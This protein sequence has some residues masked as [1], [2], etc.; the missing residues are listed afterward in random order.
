MSATKAAATAAG[1]ALLK[2]G[3][4]T[5]PA[6]VRGGGGGSKVARGLASITLHHSAHHNQRTQGVMFAGALGACAAVVGI[7]M[8][9]ESENLEGVL[10]AFLL[11]KLQ[12][13]GSS[14]A[15]ARIEE[16]RKKKYV[17]T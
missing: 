9:V 16:V 8:L 3:S 1:R 15:L 10:P 17:V 13:Q 7:A 6:A 11:E 12:Q 2:A 5:L 14:A 4:C